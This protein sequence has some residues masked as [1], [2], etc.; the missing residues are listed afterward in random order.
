MVRPPARR[1]INRAAPAE[2][3]DDEDRRTRQTKTPAEKWAEQ[4]PPERLK[5]RAK[6]IGYVLAQGVGLIVLTLSFVQVFFHSVLHNYYHLDFD[7][8]PAR[9]Q[10]IFFALCGYYG[11]PL[12][13]LGSGRQ[14]G[15]LR[16]G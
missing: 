13:G 2:T 4:S 3:G 5:E 9:A 15:G 1:A 16:T 14:R 6:A 10:D 7:I 12:L 11:I 8:D